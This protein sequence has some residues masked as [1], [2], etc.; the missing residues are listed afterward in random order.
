M[1]ASGR[2]RPADVIAGQTAG[3]PTV[4]VMEG[5]LSAA[6]CARVIAYARSAEREEDWS[7]PFW[8]QPDAVYRAQQLPPESDVARLLLE[9]A[10][11]LGSS[12]LE[13]D[14]PWI[15]WWRA[16]EGGA[17]LD[18]VHSDENNDPG[19]V[20]T[21]L[22]YLAD[23]AA[24]GQTLFPA[25]REDGGEDAARLRAHFARLA[26]ADRM[27][28]Q[29][30]DE[31]N[32]AAD[33]EPLALLEAVARGE[34]EIG[35]RVAPRAGRAAVFTYEGDDGS[36]WHGAVRV[37]ADEKWTCQMFCKHSQAKKGEQI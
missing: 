25:A 6:E 36:G 9:R 27:L 30:D 31:D 37:G 4:C 32:D 15:A 16:E 19:R 20:G 21:V 33:A 26:G 34:R 22:V 18:N 5:V 13:C 7:P 3:E 14:A 17:R 8:Q 1:E 12:T 23:T 24:G 28:L 11:L 29:A 10:G 2:M 35:V